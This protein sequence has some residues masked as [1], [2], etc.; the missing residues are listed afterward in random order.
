MDFKAVV[1]FTAIVIGFIGYV[2]YFQNIFNGK[3]K[4]HAFSWLI[5]G[6]LTAIA[7][8]GQIE[9]N[10]G[11]GAW[12]TGFSAAICLVIF[13]IALIKGSKDFPL[14]DWLALAGSALALLLWY[15]TNSPLA[16]VILITIIDALG[17]IPTFRKSFYRPNEET[18]FTFSMS[19]LKFS[20][21]IIALNEYSI[22]TVLYPLSLVITNIVFVS[23]VL[24]RR[25]SKI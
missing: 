23:M 11:P 20:L 12:V 19:A 14:V 1:G 24:T 9:G 13:L 8:F 25:K 18:T 4:P 17:F 16:A 5:W 6:I 7:F 15:L 3:T 10:A 2:P 22:I 21:G